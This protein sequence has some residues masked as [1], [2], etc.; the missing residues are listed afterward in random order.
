MNDESNR[1]QLSSLKAELERVELDLRFLRV[2]ADE[3]ESRIATQER[4]AS[5]NEILQRLVAPPIIPSALELPKIEPTP[6]H[7]QPTALAAE[8]IAV[9]RP[10]AAPP[11]IVKTP[12]P[13]Y[14][15]SSLATELPNVPVAPV[16]LPIAPVA[17]TSNAPS[18]E[19]KRESFEMRLGTYWFVRIGIVMVLTAMVFL[20][21]YAYQH[22]VGLLGP[23]GKV[24][25]MYLTSAG[26]LAA[27]KILPR[28]QERLKN[29]GQV[30]FAGGL[31]AVYFTTYA[32]HHFPN[33]QVISSPVLDGILLL[34]WTSFIVWLADRNKSEVLAVFAIGLAYY[35]ALITNV[36]NFTLISNLLLAVAAVFFLIRNRWIALTFLSIAASYGSYFYWH[37]YAG[38]AG[39]EEFAGRLSIAGYWTI[40]TTAVFLSRA[41]EFAGPRRAG[42]LSFNNAAAFG[43]LTFSFL[44]Q[45]SG[46]FWQLAL[47]AGAILLALSYLALKFIPED[48]LPR[49]AYLA[50][51]ILLITLGIITKL[52]G[53]TLALVLGVES[54]LL[55]I[56]S[57]QWKSRFVRAASIVIAALSAG[58]FLFTTI[59]AVDPHAW[60]QAA[61]LVALLLFNAGWSGKHEPERT[62]PLSIRELPAYFTSLSLFTWAAATFRLADSL[63]MAPILAISA[64][65]LTGLYYIVRVREI[66]LLAQALLGLAQGQLVMLMADQQIAPSWTPAIVAGIS[67]AFA[68]WWPRQNV[69]ALDTNAKRFLEIIYAIASALITQ[70]YLP[71]AIRGEGVITAAWI[72]TFA[73][74]ALGLFTRSWPIAAAGQ[75]FLVV[76]WFNRVTEMFFGNNLDSANHSLEIIGALLAFVA[77]AHWLNKRRATKPLNIV[78]HVYQWAAAILTLAWINVHVGEPYRFLVLAALFAVSLIIGL[79]G[80]PYTTAPGVMLATTGLFIWISGP[81][82]ALAAPQ[83]LLAI[84]IIGATQILARRKTKHLQLPESVHQ[85]W[86]GVTSGALWLYTSRWVIG[87]SAGAHFYLTASWA[88]LAFILFGLGF[89]LRERTYRWTALTVLACALARVVMLDVWKLETIYRILSFF[90]LGIVLLALGYFYTRFQEK[91][92][93]WL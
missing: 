22:Y 16:I 25:L 61:G 19:P 20:G 65:V 38:S 83:H 17:P 27:G 54:A 90:A 79:A 93:K 9:P 21:N 8:T 11:I 44:H 45:H 14:A 1:S 87:H 62:D 33:L 4:A 50:Q 41:A 29:Y 7:Q 23:I 67:L 32:A 55:L 24:V 43:L 59:H 37:Y 48:E 56:F 74:A 31:A 26:L 34:A 39:I 85:L 92:A 63:Q 3:L 6:I 51:G 70:L 58:W 60:A 12:A 15:A 89:A 5:Q 40:F 57:T 53:P 82:E 71:Q 81:L 73:W 46:K 42:F 86:L 18:T 52:S 77:L 49:R 35:T 10:A 36:G 13:I 78:A 84:L 88:I 76:G 64:V 69:L 68:L 72:L 66:P 47:A 2:K 28:K 75:L 91:I 80:I 30:L